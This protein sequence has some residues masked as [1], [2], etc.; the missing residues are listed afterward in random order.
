VQRKKLLTSKIRYVSI[1]S[2]YARN[3]NVIKVSHRIAGSLAA[4]KLNVDK[5]GLSVLIL[6]SIIV[7]LILGR[8][9]GTG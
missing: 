5:R 6:I 7:L 8:G 4:R 9:A 1:R 3:V 2:M